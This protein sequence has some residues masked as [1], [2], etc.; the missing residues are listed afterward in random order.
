M[1]IGIHGKAGSGKD[2]FATYLSEMA[3]TEH[4]F[5]GCKIAFADPIKRYAKD[6]FEF[7][8]EQLWGT[9]EK[10][11]SPDKRYPRQHDFNDSGEC[12][13][14]GAHRDSD[15]QC[16]LTPRYSLQLMGSQWG[17]KCYDDIWVQKAVNTA[18]H[19]L[20]NDSDYV[21]QHGTINSS[22]F[23]KHDFINISDLRFENEARG[24]RRAGAL[25][26]KVK[27]P[28]SSLS[29]ASANHDSEWGLPDELF[30]EIILND[31]VLDS[32]FEKTRNFLGRITPSILTNRH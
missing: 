24:L 15:S 27:R 25:L 14:C 12:F 16:Y 32:F 20:E 26:V 3:K 7:S 13:C 28:I 2:T 5:R 11:N 30:D 6:A 10:R 17:R 18:N 9:S 4:G 19:L 31:S 21:P 1:I 22:I 8:D 29:G 23:T